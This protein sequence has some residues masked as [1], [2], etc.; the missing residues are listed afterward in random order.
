[1]FKSVTAGNTITWFGPGGYEGTRVNSSL[2]Q[3]HELGPVIVPRQKGPNPSRP[4]CGI[5]SV[6]K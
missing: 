4:C 3:R 1:M 5:A 2:T 6:L